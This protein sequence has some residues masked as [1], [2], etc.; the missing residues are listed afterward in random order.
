MMRIAIPLVQGQLSPHFGHCE[1]FALLD[2]DSE[3]KSIVAERKLTSPPHQPGLLP[4][5][6]AEQ[7]ATVIVAGGM[8]TRAQDLFA[9]NGIEVVL[10]APSEDAT[11]IAE[12]FLSGSL[13]TGENAC[14]H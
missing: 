8:G 6:L 12:R 1:E 3:S 9:Q 13:E 10:G 5:W 2:A 14:D 4:R 11:A 7:G